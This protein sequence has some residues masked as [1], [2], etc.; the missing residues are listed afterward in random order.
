MWMIAYFPTLPTVLLEYRKFLP[1][2]EKDTNPADVP[3]EFADCS[4][5]LRPEGEAGVR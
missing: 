5:H 4:M 2:N 3:N 1:N